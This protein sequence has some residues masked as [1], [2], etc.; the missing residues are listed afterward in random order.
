MGL[1][2]HWEVLSVVVHV[3]TGWGGRST[4]AGPWEHGDIRLM[5]AGGASILWNVEPYLLVPF[6]P[7]IS[8]APVC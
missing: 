3:E 7:N 4:C 6:A 5:W 8:H 1:M 2:A